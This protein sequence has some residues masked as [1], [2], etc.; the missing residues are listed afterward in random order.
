[1]SDKL[2]SIIIPCYNYAQY[3]PRAINSIVKQP[4]DDFEIIIINDGSTD[5]T[6]QV[7]RSILTTSDNISYFYQSNKGS[8]AARNS[9]VQK[10]NAKYL[11][12]LDADDELLPDALTNFRSSILAHHDKQIFIGGHKSID[13]AGKEREDI[14]S[15]PTISTREQFFSAY[16]FKRLSIST[17][18]YTVHHTIF[19]KLNFPEQLRST[20]DIPFIAHALALF[21]STFI[22]FPLVKIHKHDD[23][24]RHNFHYAKEIGTEMVDTLFNEATLPANLMKYR[25]QYYLKRCLSLSGLAYRAGAYSQARKWYL[26][27]ICFDKQTLLKMSPLKKFLFS[28]LKKETF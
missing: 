5:N 27:A 7:I 25:H 14:P 2:F 3:I 18:A 28:F 26:T 4:G 10:S 19:D 16:L 12:F 21:D 24:L 23:S 22:Q 15:T 11:I 9:G 20:E 17:G 13:T 6:E 8:A 1:M